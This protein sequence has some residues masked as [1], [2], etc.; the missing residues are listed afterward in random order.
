M[1]EDSKIIK[2]KSDISRLEFLID[3][4]LGTINDLEC[5]VAFWKG[6]EEMHIGIE[7]A[8]NQ[9]RIEQLNIAMKYNGGYFPIRLLKMLGF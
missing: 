6:K 8:L 4:H 7:S 9:F 3:N 5:D 1:C 2:L